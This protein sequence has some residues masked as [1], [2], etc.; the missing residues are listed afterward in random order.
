MNSASREHRYKSR[1]YEVVVR[2][3]VADGEGVELELD[4]VPIEVEYRGGAY[5]CLMA[6]AYRSFPTLDDLIEELL[7]D[8]GVLWSLHGDVRGG[9]QS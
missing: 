3:E 8:E 9:T 6:H 5:Y 4:G 7:R 2:E 1:G